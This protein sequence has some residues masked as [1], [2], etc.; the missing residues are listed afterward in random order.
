M[1][2][3]IFYVREAGYTMPTRHADLRASHVADQ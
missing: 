2:S 3:G 1:P